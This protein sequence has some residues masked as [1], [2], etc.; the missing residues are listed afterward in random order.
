MK[1]ILHIKVLF[2]AALLGLA[3]SCNSLLEVEAKGNITGNIYTTEEGIQNALNGA[4][5]NL[6]GIFDGGDGGELFGGDFILIPS[7]LVV[8]NVF[9]MNWDNVNGPTYTD[10]YERN[11]LAINVRVENNWRRAYETI[12]TL[13]SILQSIDNVSAANRD[14]IEGEALAM[15]GM[16]YFEMVRLWGPEY[17]TGTLDELVLPLLLEPVE[18][19]GVS[20]DRNTVAQIYTQVVDDLTTASGLLESLGKNGTNISYYTCQAFLMRAAMHMDDFATAVTH[21]DNI[22]D[23]GLFSLED[24]PQEA[25]NNTSN[26]S[27][28]IFA[29]QQTPAYNSGNLSTGTGIVN[30]YSSLSSQGL[31]AMRVSQFYLNNLFGDFAYSPEFS[32]A[33]L[34]GSK[35]ESV[36][37]N[38]TADQIS[39]AFYT[40]L[41]NNAT[42]SPSKFMASDRVIP[43][44]RYAEVL[45]TRA[46]AM[47]FLSP[48]T[49]DATALEDYNDVRER[50]GLSRLDASDFSIGIDLYDSVLVERRREFLYE[51]ILYHDMKR[52]NNAINGISLSDP[53]FTLPIPQSELDAGS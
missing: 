11:I 29:I 22:V 28:D 45:L 8:E 33:D 51:G 36:A 7:L 31:G 15:R 35:D 48:V 37:S 41:L 14:R 25:F 26:S 49:P 32:A 30:Y 46:E 3:V 43:I 16:L 4:Y 17:S 10:F 1:S 38:A 9:E 42:L 13:N 20:P 34:R 21:A 50:A 2:V 12:N 52:R 5:F 23:S 27:E 24:T 19:P 18:V 53:R 44:V 39:A 47:S 40:N 6:G